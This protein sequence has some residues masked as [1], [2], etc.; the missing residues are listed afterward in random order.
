MMIIEEE[1]HLN[2]YDLEL[3]NDTRFGWR[4]GIRKEKKK[5]QNCRWKTWEEDSSYHYELKSRHLLHLLL[6]LRKWS[7]FLVLFPGSVSVEKKREKVREGWRREIRKTFGETVI[8]KKER[9]EA[10]RDTREGEESLVFLVLSLSSLMFSIAHYNFVISSHYFS[11]SEVHFSLSL[12][13]S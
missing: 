8:T 10:A 1:T 4:E 11:W 6:C 7:H 3:K 2:R 5:E 13:L 9:K 12:S